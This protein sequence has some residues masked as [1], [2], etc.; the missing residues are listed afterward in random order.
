MFD[1]FS[2][3]QQQQLQQITKIQTSSILYSATVLP[4]CLLCEPSSCRILLLIIQQ[5]NYE[6]CSV[7]ALLN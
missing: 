4:V 5:T 2:R 7:W 6:E 3:Q 1:Q